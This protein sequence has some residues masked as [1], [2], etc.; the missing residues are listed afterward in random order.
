MSLAHP[1]ERGYY[2]AGVDPCIGR[3]VRAI[4]NAG[5]QTV[6]S[7]CGHGARPASIALED[8]R[9]ILIMRDYEEARSLDH[10]WPPIP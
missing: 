8:G 7:C 1:T 2:Y 3:L 10:L 6:A 9:E 5:I 4:N